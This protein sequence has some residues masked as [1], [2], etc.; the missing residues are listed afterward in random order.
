M[1]FHPAAKEVGESGMIAAAQLAV[2]MGASPLPSLN[3]IH[4]WNDNKGKTQIGLGI[5]YWRRQGDQRGGVLWDREPEPMTESDYA[6]Y[7]IDHKMLIGAICRGVRLADVRELREL[8]IP[9]KDIMRLKG[10]VGIGVCTRDEYAKNGRPLVWSAIKRAETDFYKQAFPF[11]PGEARPGAGLAQDPDGA[12]RP[13]NGPQWGIEGHWVEPD[14]DNIIEGMTVEDAN[15]D[16]FGEQDGYEI[17]KETGEILEGL[18]F[19]DIRS[20]IEGQGD[21]LKT[22]MLAD[23]LVMT[24]LYQ[25]THHA[26]ASINRYPDLPKGKTL[27]FSSVVY[28][29]TAIRIFDWCVARKSDEEE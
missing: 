13:D 22:G 2:F 27:K 16:L 9:I 4:I 8:D 12:Y 10:V 26:L 5:N 19:A 3:E 17:D 28:A 18:Q 29:E 15:D 23:R 24:K 11:M 14:D 6:K 1:Q 25:N 21:T 7:Q 20:D